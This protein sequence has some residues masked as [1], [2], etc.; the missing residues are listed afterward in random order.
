MIYKFNKESTAKKENQSAYE[1]YKRFENG[2]KIENKQ[3][4]FDELWHSD[5][6]RTGV[7][8]QMGW[9]F[10]FREFFK[11][12]LIKTKYGGWEEIVAPNKMFIRVNSVSPSQI[13]KI[14]EL[15]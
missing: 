9:S 5:S 2:E 11:T 10:N 6:Y 14:I 7:I 3:P 12:F 13:L 4:L 1:L 15:E 8:R